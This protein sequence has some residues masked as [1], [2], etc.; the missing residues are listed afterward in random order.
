MSLATTTHRL[1]PGPGTRLDQV[2]TRLQERIATVTDREPLR[3]VVAALS[4]EG[5]LGHP[6]HP[7][8]VTVPA[9]A[10]AVSAWYD[11]RSARIEDPESDKVADAA[12]RV[13]LVAAIPAALTGIA[14]F[15]RTDGEARRVAAVHW[16]LNITAV[17]LYSISAALRRRGRRSAGRR[18]S[19]VALGVVGPGAYL[20]SHLTYRLGVG[21]ISTADNHGGS[22]N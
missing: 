16:A 14:Q 19:A 3:K 6:A 5:W 7:A 13:G 12:L 1:I 9:G 15:L 22:H 18:V 10:W 11:A 2:A 8:I 17:T 21:R 20:G 4:G